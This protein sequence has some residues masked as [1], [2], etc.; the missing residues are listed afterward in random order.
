MARPLALVGFSVYA[1]LVLAAALGPEFSWPLAALCLGL[2]A[3]CGIAWVGVSLYGR[4][5]RISCEKELPV[6]KPGALCA[7]LGGFWV[8]LAIGAM[9]LSYQNAWNRV[10]P[11]W[12]LDGQTR[13]IWGQVLEYPR[14]Q[15]H[16]YYYSIRV[17]GLGDP[18]GEETLQETDPFTLRLSVSLPLSCQPGDWVECDVRFYAFDYSGG[19]FSL[20]NSRLA[21]GISLG[22]TL[23][24]YEG[25]QVVEDPV[26]PLWEL[27][28]RLRHRL[29]RELD[30]RLPQREAGLIRAIALGDNS[31]LSQEDISNFRQLGVS[32]ILVVSGLHMTALAGFLHLLFR[33]TAAVKAVRN[34]LTGLV[35]FVFLA[36]TGFSP[37]ACRG[38]AMYGVILVADSFGRP[39]DS[40][41]SL[42][43]AV[44]LVCL[45]DPF[46][47]GDMGFALSVLATLGILLA[48]RPLY[49]MLLGKRGLSRRGP[50]KG[51]ASSLALTGSATLGTFSVQMASFRGFSLLLPLANL[52][53][54]LPGTL[55]LYLSFG[56]LMLAV[57]PPLA[58]L[59]EPF[60]WAAGWVSRL[61]L[62]TGAFLAQGKGMF[63]AVDRWAPLMTVLGVLV[64]L[65]GLAV[66]SLGGGKA[67][68]VRRAVAVICG[69][70]IL[71]WSWQM[72]V[73]YRQ[74]FTLVVPESGGASC[75]VLVSQ[76]RAAV[77][78]LGGYQT[79]TVTEVLNRRGVRSV[80]TLCLP[81]QDADALE[82]AAQVLEKYG[83][84][85]LVLP[86]G[87]YR[88]QSLKEAPE[89]LYLE[90]GDTF[91]ALP[92][93]TA[94]VL[95][96][97]EGVRLNL[98]GVEVLVEWEKAQKQQCEILVTCLEKSLVNSSFT[99][100]Q[101]DAIIEEITQF[102]QEGESL[103]LPVDTYSV[104]VEILPGGRVQTRREG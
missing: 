49:G 55:L 100:W 62:E 12:E 48:Y 86:Q 44:L 2:A 64:L 6:Q 28:A 58:P 88:D 92:G 56:G 30:Q 27:L 85:Q 13:T 19:L 84:R 69:G 16:T 72:D 94:E 20:R 83:T 36:L 102:P 66:A 50:W 40:L 101:T 11:C 98:Y 99:V 5:R 57:C 71:L 10:S 77:L 9:L 103:V 96:R 47:G 54:V 87:T 42:G 38:A 25:V 104:A 21:D 78:S 79:G 73:G 31:R 80:E 39:A 41:N 61:F 51:I 22:A 8:F 82:G 45:G 18:A 24:Q 52:L 68:W 46:S 93:V 59:C 90:G 32:H 34:L 23:V 35:L 3:I 37:S 15:Y 60:L 53:V 91:Q 14:E 43:L 26:T 89:A 81:M 4:S 97:W 29:G 76:D 17:E 70:G 95:P 63:W 65:L 74:A 33:K 7:F 75:V 1:A 67:R